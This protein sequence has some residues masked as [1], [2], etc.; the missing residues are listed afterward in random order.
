VSAIPVFI[1]YANRPDLLQRAISFVPRRMTTEPIVINNS[2]DL[3]D[4]QCKVL[5]PPVPL[6]FSQSQNWMLRYAK[7]N[8]LPF[9]M[10][11]HC[12]MVL[13]PDHVEKLY[14]IALHECAKGTKWGVIFT[15]YDIL[16]A[17]STAAADAIGGYD[18][19]FF[20]YCSDQDF[21]RRL[22]LAGYS[23]HE[24]HLLTK[25]DG[26]QTINSDPLRRH[27]VGLQTPYRSMLYRE[28]WGG[29]PGQE[30]FNQPWGGRF[31]QAKA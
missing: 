9:Y 12:D 30:R 6:T 31:G 10:W 15:F 13:E 5:E 1:P 17:Y 25:H 27:I 18:T 4:V 28:K 11:G 19:A 29:E 23:R 2:G 20:D 26:S 24:S 14:T 16:C 3:L 21:Y 22:D 7:E 8:R